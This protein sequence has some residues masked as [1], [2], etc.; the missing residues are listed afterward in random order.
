MLA[1]PARTVLVIGARG[2]LWSALS[3]TVPAAAALVRWVPEGESEAALSECAPWPWAVVSDLGH[4]PAGLRQ[5]ISSN[6]VLA[7]WLGP[8]PAELAGLVRCHQRWQEIATSI[9]RA[10]E[11]RVAGI[12]LAPDR[13][14]LT[15]AGARVNSATLEA[16]VASHPVPISLRPAAIAGVRRVLR[17]HLIP[18]ALV[19]RGGQVVLRGGD[20]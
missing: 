15:P 20:D 11:S 2:N 9:C 14:V 10:L 17:R 1:D 13:G 12:S 7:H 4:A 19:T 6:P 5:A 18:V 3:E 16:L 8:P